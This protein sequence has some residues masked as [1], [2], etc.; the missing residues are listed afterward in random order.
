MVQLRYV[1]VRRILAVLLGAVVGCAAADSQERKID[2]TYLHQYVPD[3]Q[4]KSADISTETC[5]YTPIF[6]W[7]DPA[8]TASI[9]RGVARFG[10]LTIKAH[11]A[12]KEVTYPAEEQAWVV[13]AGNGQLHYGGETSSVK[14]RDFFYIPATVA[15]S[16]S[17]K[18]DAPVQVFIMGFKMEANTPPPP[19]LM[20][21]NID[22]IKKQVLSSHPDSVVYQLMMGNAN[23]KR[24]RLAAAHLL[25]S[26]Y[27]M[28]FQ[29]GG[30]NFPHH[31]DSE[32]EIYFL[33]DGRGEMVAGDGPD[34]L[35]GRHAAKPGD[36]YFFRE[37]CTVGFYNSSDGPAHILAVRS[38]FPRPSYPQYVK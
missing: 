34:G 33:M 26:L 23:S 4:S 14:A 6:G 27:V 28:G 29:P 3:L 11:G 38:V 13:M 15:H 8:S 37:N 1:S 18:S 22:E 10:E 17:N 24:D 25:T 12:C 36:A 16:I 35:E 20:L 5:Q 31:H 7:G 9:M 21:A 30:T 19:K 2:P 32:E